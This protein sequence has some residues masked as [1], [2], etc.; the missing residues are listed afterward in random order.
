MSC[1]WKDLHG[2]NQTC[3]EPMGGHVF[4]LGNYVYIGSNVDPDYFL[5]E[6]A[7]D[8]SGHTATPIPADFVDGEVYVKNRM[9]FQAFTDQSFTVP[10]VLGRYDDPGIFTI[11]PDAFEGTAERF[12]YSDGAQR[13]I[14]HRLSDSWM[15]F[16]ETEDGEVWAPVPGSVYIDDN[17]ANFPGEYAKIGSRLLTAGSGGSAQFY[18]SDNG[19]VTWTPGTGVVYGGYSGGSPRFAASGSNIIATKADIYVSSNNGVSWARTPFSA[20]FAQHLAVS[21]NGGVIVGGKIPS[22]SF[23]NGIA[24]S[25]DHGGSWTIATVESV[26]FPSGTQMQDLFWDGVQFVAFVWAAGVGYS[27]YTSPTGAAW[28][29]AFALPIDNWSGI[30]QIIN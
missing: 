19:G 30:S 11:I 10:T 12:R 22:Q 4:P 7:K 29:L 26:G 18:Y 23:A 17:V 28:T 24:Y 5:V 8:F 25:A 13:V 21:G 14:E 15:R 9:L 6:I 20:A 3:F 27:A 1:F 16:M 2:T